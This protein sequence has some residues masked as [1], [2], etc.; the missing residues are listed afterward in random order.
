[1]RRVKPYYT[2]PSEHRQQ[3]LLNLG[4][5]C[6]NGCSCVD[7]VIGPKGVFVAV[8]WAS[9]AGTQ[10][11]ALPHRRP[12][13]KIWACTRTYCEMWWVII[14]FS[15]QVS[16]W[17]AEIRCHPGNLDMIP[18]WLGCDSWINSITSRLWPY[19]KYPRLCLCETLLFVYKLFTQSLP[20]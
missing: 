14:T 6:S 11:P 17:H 18:R 16:S 4:S 12:T 3:T 19:E 15:L 1:M 20:D 9:S 2:M 7:D 8:E 5:G 10:L 13:T